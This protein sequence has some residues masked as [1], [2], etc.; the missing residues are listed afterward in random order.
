MYAQWI[1][2]IYDITLNNQGAYDAGTA[3]IYEKYSTGF[4]SDSAVI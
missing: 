3:H 4:Y 2:N 1:P